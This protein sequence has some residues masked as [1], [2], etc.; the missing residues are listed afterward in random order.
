MS[1]CVIVESNYLRDFLLVYLYLSVF[2]KQIYLSMKKG[3]LNNNLNITTA[4]KHQ[5]RQQ[6]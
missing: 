2:V 5:Y 3:L 4:L 1:V 6:I